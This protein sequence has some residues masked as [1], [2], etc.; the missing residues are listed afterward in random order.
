[1]A[2]YLAEPRAN[3]RARVVAR[4]PRPRPVLLRRDLL[5][6]RVRD[7]E[8]LADGD[9]RAIGAQLA[10]DVRVSV[11]RVEHDHD[12]L[13]LSGRGAGPGD[14]VIV[15]RRAFDHADPLRERVRLDRLAVVRADVDVDA[16]Y[17]TLAH[18]LEDG[19]VE[20]ERPAAGDSRLDH[21]LRPRLPD[22]FLQG[23]D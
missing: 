16:E 15:Q 10:E 6:E 8:K 17:L 11:V 12:A 19:C 7:D 20:H 5:D 18:Q 23:D 21:E 1:E 2:V 3:G 22:H 9:E 4:P 14:D 13:D